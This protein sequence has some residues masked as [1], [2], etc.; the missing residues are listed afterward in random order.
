MSDTFHLE[1]PPSRM[2]LALAS[3]MASQ[4]RKAQKLNAGPPYGVKGHPRRADSK[5]RSF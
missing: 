4:E 1:A 2:I 3:A 5:L